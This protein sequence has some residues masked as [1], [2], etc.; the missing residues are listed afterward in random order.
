MRLGVAA[1]AALFVGAFLAHFLLE[2]R[3]YVLIGLK[4]WVIETSVPA[5]VMGLV[6]LYAAVRALIAVAR[7]PRRLR[8]ALAER[9]L[10]RAGGRLTHGLVHLVEGDWRRAERV[11]TQGLKGSDAPLANYLLAA[12]AAHR[13]GAPDRRDRW[14]KLAAERMPDAAAAVALTEAELALESGDAA[15]ARTVLEPLLR[16]APDHPGAVALLARAHAALGDRRQLA[17]L[18]PRLK[19][20]ALDAGAL[21]ALAAEA[22]AAAVEAP[23]LTAEKLEALWA[24]LP[25]A[26]RRS[27][28][29]VAR[30]ALALQQVGRPDDAERE[31]KAALKRSFAAPLV[32]AYGEVRSSD[33]LKQLRQAEAWLETHPED[34]VLLATAAKLCIANELWGKARSYLESSIAIAPDADAYALYGRLLTQLGEAERAAQA[35]KSGLALTSRVPLEAPALSPPAADA[36]P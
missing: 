6:L 36:K 33:V 1:L 28:A 35:F 10:R 16:R 8:G 15:R 22:F 3:G 21:E 34:P 26:L 2:D 9:Q 5:L 27:P 18:L 25:P 13:Q 32:A 17:E 12:R 23:D 4:G 24:A 19:N 29:L 11:L 20:A 7:A 30:R 31:L 14:L